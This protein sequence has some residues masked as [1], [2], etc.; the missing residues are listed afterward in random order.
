[1][2]ERF[3]IAVRKA[4][5]LGR[6]DLPTSTRR[7]I[8]SPS[9]S[10][11]L[12]PGVPE[13]PGRRRLDRRQRIASTTRTTIYVPGQAVRS[14]TRPSSEAERRDGPGVDPRTACNVFI[15]A[16]GM[17]G[18]QAGEQASRMAVEIIP[19]AI[20][21]GSRPRRPTP[22]PIQ[23]AIREAV[24]E[25][26]QEILGSSG[27][28]TEYS[29]MGTTVVLALFRHDRVY[30]AGIGDS[31]AY[32]LRD[33]Q[34]RATHQGPLAGRRPG[35]GRHDHQG[36]AAEPQVQESSSTCTWAARTRGA[37]PRTSGCS[38]SRRATGSC[39]PATV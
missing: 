12:V 11:T 28:V 23:S 35:R 19:K 14:P 31:R 26:N 15:V 38:T 20:A 37:A 16:D 36:R 29:N 33:G 39:S 1:M 5:G 18:Q 9:P 21:R 22:R 7:I 4:S 6:R 30:V 32:R 8:P 10:L 25:A 13:T 2:R 17:G 24:A 27:A 34:L 3:T